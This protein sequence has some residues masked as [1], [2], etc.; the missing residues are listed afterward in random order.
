MMQIENTQKA[1]HG[2]KSLISSIGEM[3]LECK[4]EKDKNH[5]MAN[6]INKMTMKK[7]AIK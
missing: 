6:I 4:A 5:F 2:I 7:T 3:K 1:N